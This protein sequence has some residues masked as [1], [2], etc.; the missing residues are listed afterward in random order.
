MLGVDR[1]GGET[2]K[3]DWMGRRAPTVFSLRHHA[4]PVDSESKKGKGRRDI[5]KV[6]NDH[7][8]IPYL[9]TP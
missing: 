1:Y 2:M 4:G 8:T 5:L 3:M 9:I 7:S 6:K